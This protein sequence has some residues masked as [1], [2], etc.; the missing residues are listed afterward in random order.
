MCW[1]MTK[2]LNTPV[3]IFNQATT[4][5][6]S[7][8]LPPINLVLGRVNTPGCTTPDGWT[9][10]FSCNLLQYPTLGKEFTIATLLSDSF[11]LSDKT[12][13]R[14]V[15]IINTVKEATLNALTVYKNLASA[16]SIH[17]F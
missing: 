9:V 5:T 1:A 8:C 2:T 13:L 3:L 12:D 7:Y 16:T 14:E 4:P 11:G 17:N 15:S 6:T 10:L